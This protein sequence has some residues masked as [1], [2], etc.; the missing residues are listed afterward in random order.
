MP[1]TGLILV[2]LFQSIS[3]D[4]QASLAKANQAATETFSNMKTV[5]SFANEDGETEKYKVQLDET[6]ALNK[7]EA[8]AYAGN[9]W[10]NTVS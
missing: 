7:K 4:V 2:S 5:K 6:Y 3:R 10:A 8:A 1:Q 9:M